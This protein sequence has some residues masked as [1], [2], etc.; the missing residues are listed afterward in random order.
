MHSS[1]VRVQNVFGFFTSVAFAVAAAIALSVLLSPQA[2]SASLELKNVKVAKG[3]PHYYSPKREEYAHVTFDL[4]TDLTSLFNWNTKQV[5]LW[6]EASY[7]STSPS[8]IPSS[9]AV[10]WDAIIPSSYAP[11]HQNT[12]IHPIA[13]KL[14]AK[15]KKALKNKKGLPYPAGAS[16]GI[17]RLE[18]QKPKYQI[19]DVT[20][21]M[22]GRENATLTL[23][24]NVQPWV[25]MLTWT[26]R[27]TYGRWDGLK[28]G[29]SDTFA[30]P[31]LKGSETV[32]KEDL[33]TETGGERNRGSPA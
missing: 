31:P 3:R 24:W 13:K 17:V 15:E 26:N 14:T 16:P 5:F 7:P 9:E 21:K 12:Y 28:G 27:K 23:H 33:K 18:G 25:G 19:T 30:F 1:L 29:K 8:T 6:V 11:F 20:G 32:K 2:P 4:N 10:I 22:A